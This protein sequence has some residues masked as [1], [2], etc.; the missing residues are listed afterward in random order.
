MK[1]TIHEIVKDF[2]VTSFG[3]SYFPKKTIF[4]K[5]YEIQGGKNALKDG[6]HLTKYLDKSIYLLKTKSF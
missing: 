3:K 2:E 4:I 5:F 1:M 6:K